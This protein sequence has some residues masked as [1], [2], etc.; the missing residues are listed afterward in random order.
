MVAV[1]ISPRV[2]VIGLGRSGPAA[3]RR[4][5]QKTVSEQ[6]VLLAP[7][8]ASFDQFAD[9]GERGER[10]AALVREEVAPCP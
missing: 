1:E 6:W 2:P 10:F 4:A 7:A 3:V 8:C 5:R 9:Y